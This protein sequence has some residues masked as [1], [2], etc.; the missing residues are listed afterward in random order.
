[1]NTQQAIGETPA[2]PLYNNIH[3][4]TLNYLPVYELISQQKVDTTLLGLILVFY[5]IVEYR[6]GAVMKVK[7]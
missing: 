5:A 2:E 1:M 4:I 6:R 3:A 7:H